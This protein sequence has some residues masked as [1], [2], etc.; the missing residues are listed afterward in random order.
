M[1]AQAFLKR[2]LVVVAVVLSLL[3]LWLLRNTLLLAFL[4]IVI[5]V[6]ISIP[7]RWLQKLG[8]GR[9]WANALSAVG[10]SLAF[11]V[12]LLWLVP[13][14]IV[15]FGDLLAGL[16]QGLSSLAQTYNSVRADSEVLSRILPPARVAGSPGLSEAEIRGLL[17]RALNTGL[18]ILISGGS[19]ALSL[20]TNF[21]LVLFIALLFLSDPLAY[22]T[23][24]LYLVP[25]NHHERVLNLWKEL[26]HTLKTWLSSLFISI[27]IT[28]SLVWIILGLLGMPHVLIVA[29]FSGFATF[30]PNIGTFLPLVPIAVFTLATAPAS[31]LIMAP[32]YLLIQLLESNVLT[33]MVVKRQLSIPAAGMLVFQLVAALA[34]GLLGVLL[35][36]PLLAVVITLVRELYS[37]DAL[38]LRKS[39]AKAVFGRE[40]QLQ[41]SSGQSAEPSPEQMTEQTPSKSP[42]SGSVA[43]KQTPAKQGAVKQNQKGK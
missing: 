3:A 31:L 1:T 32:A 15:G 9:G 34:F 10:V 20:L 25:A 41:L 35:A 42:K 24:S 2:V 38:G 8:L 18:P 13:A 26:Y 7:A 30:V 37:Y 39:S 17:E 33:P 11:L 36:V 23:A 5:A 22:V 4:G 21:V 40:G 29:V 6:G 12:L 27:T 28:V 16:P 14:L 43:V 19:V